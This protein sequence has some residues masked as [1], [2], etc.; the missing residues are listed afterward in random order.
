MEG[1][2]IG[3]V[4]LLAL[5]LVGLPVA[6]AF[7]G[8]AI[9]LV[10]WF[11]MEPGF[12]IPTACYKIKSVDCRE[13]AQKAI[14]AVPPDLVV[15]GTIS[16]RGEAFALHQWIRAT[17][18]CRAVPIVVLDVPVEKQVLAG[19]TKSSAWRLVRARCA[20]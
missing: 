13:D 20:S 8:M 4:I 14:S 5:M 10:T 11:G 16:P 6:M 17:R 18:S 2:G 1:V 15:L 3:L 7:G 19:W 9:F 12:L